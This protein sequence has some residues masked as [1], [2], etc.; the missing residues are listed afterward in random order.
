[1]SWFRKTKNHDPL[2]T[3]SLEEKP[4]PDPEKQLSAAV[5]EWIRGASARIG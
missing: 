2:P 1:M 5:S 4:K 3:I